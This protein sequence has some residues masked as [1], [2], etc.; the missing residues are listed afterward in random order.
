VSF[1]KDLGTYILQKVLSEY[2]EPFDLFP[3]P[4][5]RETTSISE[6][7]SV[8]HEIIWNLHRDDA[9]EP[10]PLLYAILIINF[11]IQLRNLIKN[12]YNQ[13]GKKKTR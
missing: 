12:N 2:K 7:F 13:N 6:L 3:Y 9:K 8:P 10:T 4:T 11:I 5:P 1:W